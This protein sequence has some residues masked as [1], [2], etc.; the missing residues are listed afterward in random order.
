[1]AEVHDNTREAAGMTQSLVTVL[2]SQQQSSCGKDRKSCSV[3]LDSMP[4]P[5]IPAVDHP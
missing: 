4:P 3:A 5:P 2:H 1:M